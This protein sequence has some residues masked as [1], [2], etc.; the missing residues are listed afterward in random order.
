MDPTPF[1]RLDLRP[2]N[3]IQKHPPCLWGACV[4]FMCFSW[5]LWGL[6]HFRQFN[7]PTPT[8]N[9]TKILTTPRFSVVSVYLRSWRKEQLPRQAQQF[10]FVDRYKDWWLMLVV[11]TCFW[12]STLIHSKKEGL[13]AIKQVFLLNKLI[14]TTMIPLHSGKKKGQKKGQVTW[15]GLHGQKIPRLRFPV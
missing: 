15:H 7:L 11:Y 5:Q 9:H 14:L 2:K 12:K 13:Y 6:N 1:L 10:L 3:L 8:R 4:C